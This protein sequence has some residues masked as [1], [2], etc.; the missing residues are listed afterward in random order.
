MALVKCA[1][2]GREVEPAKPKIGCGWAILWALFGLLPLL[3]YIIWVQSK[4]ANK[5]PA[6]GK[7]VYLAEK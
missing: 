2:C 7:N 6:C 5:C 4:P 1:N 3:I